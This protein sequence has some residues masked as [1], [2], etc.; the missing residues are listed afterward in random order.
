MINAERQKLVDLLGT[1][2]MAVAPPGLPDRI[3]R[4][5][6][7]LY[8]RWRDFLDAGADSCAYAA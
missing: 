3:I 6:P 8:L 1:I 5:W 2:G 4:R 7:L